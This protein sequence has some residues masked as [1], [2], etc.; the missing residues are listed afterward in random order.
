VLPNETRNYVPIILAMTIMAKNPSQY[1]L[2]HL[3]LD[4]PLKTDTV[5]IDYP[6]DLRLVAE[7]VDASTEQLQ[8]L[9]PSL[10]RMTTPKNMEFDLHLPAGTA[11]KFQQAVAAIPKDMRVSWRYHR[12]ESGETLS[13][14]ARRY[15]TT[16][17]AI[18]E[19]NN[20]EGD[21]LAEHAKLIIPVS[22]SY[23][24]SSGSLRY[25]RHAT[26]YRIRRGDTI[27]AVADRFGVPAEKL[28]QWNRL[29]G[30]HLIAGRYLTIFRPVGRAEDD[31]P[32]R[33][34]H[35]RRRHSSRSHSS[36]HRSGHHRRHHRSR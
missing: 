29:K 21:A 33:S 17:G 28:R 9:N 11:Q 25:S 5:R 30:N 8:A 1:G 7:C 13:A 2:D 24:Q 23:R 6:I 22:H 31:P 35:H 26:H 20:L 14:I 12:V 15:H 32:H 10:L 18:R 34:A 19:V 36:R 16:V 27:L 3:S 4:P